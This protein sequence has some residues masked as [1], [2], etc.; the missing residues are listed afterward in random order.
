MYGLIT[1]KG[2]SGTFFLLSLD[3]RRLFLE[4]NPFQLTHQDIFITVINMNTTLL[5]GFPGLL[6]RKGRV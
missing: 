2:S 5:P 3:A 6:T 4:P 1:S